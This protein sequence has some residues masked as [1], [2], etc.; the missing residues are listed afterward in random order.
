MTGI[1]GIGNRA[2]RHVPDGIG[3]ATRRS[4]SSPHVIPLVAR[5]FRRVFRTHRRCRGTR[6]K[7]ARPERL[8]ESG[9]LF[10]VLL[11][12][13]CRSTCGADPV[14]QVPRFKFCDGAVIEVGSVAWSN[15]RS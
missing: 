3:A 12:K 7:E 6:S 4:P 1:G 9:V 2:G 14:V 5:G 11:L 15:E 13:P 8:D 10:Q